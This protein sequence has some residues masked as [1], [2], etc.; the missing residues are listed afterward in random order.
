MGQFIMPF[1]FGR[2][3]VQI[4][5]VKI[6]SELLK[7]KKIKQSQKVAVQAK[8]KIIYVSI[9]QK[10]LLLMQK[11]SGLR[12]HS[13]Y[14]AILQ[15]IQ[16]LDYF[17][18]KTLQ[19][20][21]FERKIQKELDTKFFARFFKLTKNSIKDQLIPNCADLNEFYTYNSIKNLSENEYAND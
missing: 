1:C 21:C 9:W 14:V 6:N 19:H 15:L 10:I 4:E 13:N 16:N 20:S 5:M 3:D 7:I 2:P 18:E 12:V 8:F 17:I 11:E